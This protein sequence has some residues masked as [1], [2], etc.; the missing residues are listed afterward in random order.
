MTQFAGDKLRNVGLV[1]H[2][3]VGKT[4]LAE[5]M[6]FAMDET[7]RL[8]QVDAGTSIMDYDEDEIE[9]K[10][11]LSTSLGHGTWK[12]HKIN[13][14][15]TPG[16]ASFFAETEGSMRV[17]D[18]AV[19]VVSA[20]GGI[21]VQTEKAWSI[22]E[23]YGI[24]RCVFVNKMDQEGSDF[25]KVIEQFRSTY[26]Q[27]VV[28][29]YLALMEGERFTGLVDLLAMKALRFSNGKSSVEEIPEEALDQAET[30][31]HLLAF[32]IMP[33]QLHL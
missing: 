1:G 27:S 17:M 28:P 24:S 18:A 29:L 2:G 25:I 11:S 7:D 10:M 4:S 22:A 13:L 33:D 12:K 8:G 26:S 31:G 19:V 5:A 30:V 6:L 16:A 32:A 20:A 3:S 15:D 21:E 14:L 9:R 23:R